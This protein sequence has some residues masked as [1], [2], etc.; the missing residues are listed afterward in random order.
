MPADYTI[1]FKQPFNIATGDLQT[2]VNGN[3]L[4][5]QMI[6]IVKNL[7]ADPEPAAPSFHASM[8]LADTATDDDNGDYDRGIRT[9]LF[10]YDYNP[11]W[12]MSYDRVADGDLPYA[13]PPAAAY[14]FTYKDDRDEAQGFTSVVWF[15]V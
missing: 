8:S 12:E 6:V 5:M 3:A 15:T 10:I 2:D 14:S 1:E 4:P 9:T 7:L 13:V 11:D